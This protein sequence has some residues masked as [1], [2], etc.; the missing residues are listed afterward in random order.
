MGFGLEGLYIYKYM[1]CTPPQKNHGLNWLPM[2]SPFSPPRL[3][4]FVNMRNVLDQHGWKEVTDMTENF[5]L[6][7]TNHYPLFDG[8]ETVVMNLSSHQVRQNFD[9]VLKL[10]FF[11]YVEYSKLKPLFSI[12]TKRTHGLFTIKKLVLTDFFPPPI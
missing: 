11:M 1:C 12:V 9:L 10:A 2:P 4:H 6:V 5:T 7:W 3:P 8:W